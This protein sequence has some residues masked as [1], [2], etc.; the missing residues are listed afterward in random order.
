[1]I[2]TSLLSTDFIDLLLVDTPRSASVGHAE[3]R[4]VVNRIRPVGIRSPSAFSSVSAI[5]R[6]PIRQAAMNAWLPMKWS[7]ARCPALL[8]G[9]VIVE[10]TMLSRS[11]KSFSGPSCARTSV[12]LWLSILEP[13]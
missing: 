10:T 2:D 13:M 3:F 11:A 1:M 12:A 7:S 4:T 5:Q 8:G 6:C 9:W